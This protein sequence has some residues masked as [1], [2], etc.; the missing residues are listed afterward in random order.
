M[1]VLFV[2]LAVLVVLVRC[3]VSAGASDPRLKLGDVA[4]LEM[5]EMPH[6]GS[7]VGLF[8]VKRDSWPI[9]RDTGDTA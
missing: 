3:E 1:R 7:G 2:R 6:A 9:R 8:G 5:L 4:R